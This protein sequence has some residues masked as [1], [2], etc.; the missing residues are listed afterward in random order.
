MTLEMRSLGH[1]ELAAQQPRLP[2]SAP[3]DDAPLLPEST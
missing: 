3:T 2:G 1:P